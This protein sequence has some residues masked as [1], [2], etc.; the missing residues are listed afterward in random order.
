MSTPGAVA[1]AGVDEDLETSGR[2]DSLRWHGTTTTSQDGSSRELTALE[3]QRDEEEP[4]AVDSSQGDVN[5]DS[6]ISATLVEEDGGEQNGRPEER[7]RSSMT[8]AVATVMKYSWL[9]D[10]RVQV[11]LVLLLL[12]AIGL[13]VWAVTSRDGDGGS[14]GERC[15]PMLQDC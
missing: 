2:L 14:T 7:R 3:E 8:A 5:P 13:T 6:L 11:G 1:V 12:L 15:L 4:L 10:R 9:H